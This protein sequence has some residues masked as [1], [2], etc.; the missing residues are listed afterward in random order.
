MVAIAKRKKGGIKV[1][2]QAKAI[3]NT[4]KDRL[5]DLIVNFIDEQAGNIGKWAGN[6]T[7]F[8]QKVRRTIISLALLI[9]GVTVI[10]LGLGDWLAPTLGLSQAVSRVLIGFIAIVVAVI[11]SKS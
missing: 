4:Y 8:K 10:I 6:I 1:P 2:K 7:H 5:W 9:G 11:Y 3:Y